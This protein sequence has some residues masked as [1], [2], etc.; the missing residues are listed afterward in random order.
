[1]KRLHKLLQ[2]VYDAERARVKEHRNGVWVQSNTYI[3]KEFLVDF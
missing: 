3:P 2:L 1:M